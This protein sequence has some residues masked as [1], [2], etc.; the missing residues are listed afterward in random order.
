MQ[1]PKL[2]QEIYQNIRSQMQPGDIIA[3]SGRARI[4]GLIKFATSS[5]ISHIGI[6]SHALVSHLGHLTVE[7]M[8][9][10]KEA[11][12]PET[13]QL[14]TGVHRLRMSTRLRHYEG[15][16]YW[17]PLAKITRRRL[18]Y[19]AAITF[20]M[21]VLGRPYDIPQAIKCALDALDGFPGRLTYAREDY[22][23]LF[24]SELAAGALKAGGILDQTSNPSEMT[25]IDILRLPIFHNNY[26]QLKGTVHEPII[27]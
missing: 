27:F 7:V 10:V 24:C 26:Y 12:H 17:L 20:L 14:I 15:N 16:V 2:Q 25:P 5:N 22:S 18:D 1:Y 13:G 4:S 3:Y 11:V 8:E 6:V 9:S 21:N 23:S 19:T